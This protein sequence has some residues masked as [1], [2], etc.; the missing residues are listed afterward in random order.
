MLVESTALHRLPNIVQPE[1]NYGECQY[2][3]YGLAGVDSKQDVDL[4]KYEPRR[5][6]DLA[7]NR[8][9]SEQNY[10]GNGWV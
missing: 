9:Y 2:M 8:T 3:E 4:R 10:H 1:G 6:R 7:A 5:V